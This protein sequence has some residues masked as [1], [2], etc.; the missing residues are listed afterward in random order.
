[1]VLEEQNLRKCGEV[2]IT[3]LGYLK[4]IR[5]KSNNGLISIGKGRGHRYGM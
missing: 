5:F 2:S 4:L 3:V 1:M